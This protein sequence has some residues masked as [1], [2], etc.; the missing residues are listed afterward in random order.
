MTR[1]SASST[2]RPKGPGKKVIG[3]MWHLLG[4]KDR[5]G[6]VFSV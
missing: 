3:G 6:N 1:R 2:S 5:Y 4:K